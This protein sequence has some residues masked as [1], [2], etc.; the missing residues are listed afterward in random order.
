MAEIIYVLTN[1]SMPGLVKIGKTTD[2]VEARLNNLNCH[3]GVPLPFEC[4]FAAV[5]GNCTKLEQKL[6]Q[7]FAEHRINPKREFFKIDPE[8]VVLAISIGKFEEIT[9]ILSELD[10]QDQQAIE[11]VKKRKSNIS[12]YTLGINKGDI[13][14]FSRDPSIQ[15]EVVDPRKNIIEFEGKD[16]SIS[17]AAVILLRRLGNKSTTAQGPIYWM[18]EG[19]LLT[20]RRERMEKEQFGENN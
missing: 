12:L 10:Q 2:S 1:E 14:T 7:L 20:E 9:S 15:A 16:E 17:A 5:V 19:E 11:K 18:F 13:L 6:H 4:H 3:T 8:R